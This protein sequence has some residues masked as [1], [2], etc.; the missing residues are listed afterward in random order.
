[1]TERA[2]EVT[3]HEILLNRERRVLRQRAA[4]EAFGRPLLSITLVT[5]GPVKDSP[6]ARQ[7]MKHAL[8]A[9]ETLMTS[10]SWQ[11]LN[12]E[13]HF[14]PT[15]PEALFV[16]AA[17]SRELKAATTRLEDEHPI[18]RLWDIDVI[19]TLGVT[20]SRRTLDLPARRCLLC[21]EDAYL[22]V[23]SRA[24]SLPELQQAVQ[25]IVHAYRRF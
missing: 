11:V 18:G 13:E 5:P 3:L 6:T 12:R 19:D 1:M 4:I 2:V 14:D 17:S 25:E 24:H 9:L 23:R 20:C 15:G 22:C 8:H 7:I 10:R 21:A 16:V